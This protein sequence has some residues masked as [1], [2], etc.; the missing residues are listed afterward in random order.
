MECTGVKLVVLIRRES[1][2]TFKKYLNP[3]LSENIVYKCIITADSV[4][5]SL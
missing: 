2:S 3:G 4:F 5:E 1:F